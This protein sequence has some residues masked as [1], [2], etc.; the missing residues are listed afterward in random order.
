MTNVELAG[1]FEK[2]GLTSE[3]AKETAENKKIAPLLEKVIMH[4]SAQDGVPKS[5]GALYYVLA[6]TGNKLNNENIPYI[7]TAIADGRLTSSDQVA[8]AI[9]YC[10]NCTP[11]QLMDADKFNKECGVG[12]VITLEHIEKTVKDLLHLKKNDLDAKRYQMNGI[13]T[14]I[15]KN[16][17]KWANFLLVKETLDSQMLAYLGPKDA[18]DDRKSLKKKEKAAKAADSSADLGLEGIALGERRV[19]ELAASNQFILEGELSRLHKVGENPQI[20]TDLMKEHLKRTGGKVITRFPPEP[21]GFLHIGHAKAININF[22]FAKYHNGITYL[23]YDDT[24]PEAEEGEYFEAILDVV[25]WLGYTP[26]KVTYSSDHF[27]RLYELAVELIKKDKAYVCFCT[28]EEIHK[29]R[30][31]DEK[32]P[33]TSC[34]H[35]N[36]PIEESLDEFENMKNRKY[37]QGIATL[38]M[39][40]DLDNPNP[41]MW[42]LVAYRVLY[43]P[44]HR[45]KDTWCIYPTYDYTHCLC[46][47]FEDITHSICTLEFVLSRESYYWLVDALELYKPIQSEFGRLNLTNTVT[48]KRKL[49]SLVMDGYVKG[50]DDPRLPTIAGIRRRGYTPEAVN[51]FVRGIGVTFN[52]VTTQMEKLENLVRDHLN[53]ISPRH[54][55]ILEPVKV[56]ID[57]FQEAY[58][59]A[60]PAKAGEQR[61]FQKLSKEFFIDAS[62]FKEVAD[63]NFYRLSPGQCVGLLQVPHPV[64]CTGFVRDAAGKVVEIKVNLEMQSKKK[65]KTYIQWLNPDNAVTCEVRLY[66]T[67]FL[68]ENPQSHPGGWLADF[69]KDSLQ[70]VTSSILDSSVTG[71]PVGYTFQAVRVGYFCID[72]DSSAQIV[73]NRTVTLKEDKD[74]NK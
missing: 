9:R 72:K 62:D 19:S 43:T 35:R 66:D 44:H 56:T 31:G 18:R 29:H 63:S 10:S 28:G 69:N 27:Q 16:E 55:L 26:Y 30:G 20:R 13:I 46:D 34:V 14:G 49:N 41:Q 57:N 54:Y 73:L 32:G 40:M 24:N 67:L 71:H 1:L 38:R 11:G 58:E 22:G 2:I 21:N 37:S 51:A 53:E 23:R 6:S 45:T 17:L 15:L 42:D 4:V 47:S 61:R 65:P 68:N 7:A 64:T 50:W 25:E 59:C 70:V 8:A 60:L 5:V 48:S 12:V 33:R 36:R 3:K 39:K 52:N 74:K